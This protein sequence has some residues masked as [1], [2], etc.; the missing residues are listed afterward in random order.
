LQAVVGSFNSTQL[1]QALPG[2]C[3]GG[4]NYIT[5]AWEHRSDTDI[6]TEKTNRNRNKIYRKRKLRT[7]DYV[8]I[9]KIN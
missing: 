2:Y 3:S 7:R 5:K 4:T 9:T 8:I 6:D 1:L